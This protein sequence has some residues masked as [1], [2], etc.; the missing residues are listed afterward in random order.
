MESV[1]PLA[2]WMYEKGMKGVWAF[3]IAVL[4]K[5]PVQYMIIECNPRYNAASY[6]SIIGR[7][8]GNF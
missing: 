3:D 2:E 6:P 5:D 1:Q 4:E 7:K 8:L